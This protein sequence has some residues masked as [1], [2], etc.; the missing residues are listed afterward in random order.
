MRLLEDFLTVEDLEAIDNVLESDNPRFDRLVALAGLDPKKDFSYADL[1]R[2][3]FCG[4]DLRGFDF[5]G[6]D[7]RQCARNDHTII[8]PTTIFTNAKLDWIELEAL[9]I[10]VKMQ[11]VEAALNSDKRIEILNDLTSEFGKTTHV[12]KY[13]ISAAS[14]ARSIEEFLDFVQFLPKNLSERQFEILRDTSQKL[15][16]KKFAQSRKRT[17]RAATANFAAR[18]IAEK[19]KR[20]SGTLAESIY[21]K[22]AETVLSKEKVSALGGIAEVEATDIE[23]A[24]SMIGK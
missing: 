2:L 22:L 4:A 19:L 3:N 20:S 21:L 1:R 12:V 11:K 18:A 9:P 7:L 16:A 23:M 15:L 17:G 8:D 6:S 13:L 24:F 5:T 10:V 14:N